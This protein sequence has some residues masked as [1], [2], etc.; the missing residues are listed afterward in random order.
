MTLNVLLPS[1]E[2]LENDG[3]CDL[4]VARFCDQSTHTY[5]V[6]PHRRAAI[7]AANYMSLCNAF[8]PQ[9]LCGYVLLNH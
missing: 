5:S 4:C 3:S 1:V 7:A 8:E 6:L 2:Q 9:L